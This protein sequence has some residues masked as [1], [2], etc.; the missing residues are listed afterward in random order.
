MPKLPN[1]GDLLSLEE[2]ASSCG[3]RSASSLRKAARDGRLRVVR[4]GPRAIMTTLDWV[5]DYEYA[6]VGNGGR[7]RGSTAPASARQRAA[8]DP[9]AGSS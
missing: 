1:A 7:L 6:I 3:Y 4:L 2:A 8:A 5:S 9:S